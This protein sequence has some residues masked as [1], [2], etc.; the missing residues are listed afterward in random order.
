MFQKYQSFLV[1]FVHKNRFGLFLSAYFPFWESLKFIVFRKRNSKPLQFLSAQ[2]ASLRPGLNI[3]PRA[4]SREPGARA[5]QA[6]PLDPPAQ[7]V[8]S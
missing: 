1:S 4:G 2:R 8:K 5:P 7:S 3:K 6:P